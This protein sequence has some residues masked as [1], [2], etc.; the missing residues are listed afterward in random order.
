MFFTH[1]IRM[2]LVIFLLSFPLEAHAGAMTTIKRCI[3]NGLADLPQKKT[4]RELR[5]L[6]DRYTDSNI[7]GSYLYHDRRDGKGWKSASAK[8]RS[9]GIDMFYM[10]LRNIS[11]KSKNDLD[12]TTTIVTSE[13]RGT[14]TKYLAGKNRTIYQVVVVAKDANKKRTVFTVHTTAQCKIID[15]QQGPKLSA[16]LN[17]DT[18]E[19]AYNK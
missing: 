17:W 2:F 13:L 7:L 11:K 10:R 3:Q 6:F 5:S 12:T 4:E 16:G 9:Y 1:L 8:M 18:L 15:L 19:H 14:Y